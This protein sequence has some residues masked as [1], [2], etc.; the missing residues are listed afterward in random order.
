MKFDLKKEPTYLDRLIKAAYEINWRHEEQPNGI[1]VLTHFS[2]PT[3]LIQIPVRPDNFLGDIR[4]YAAT[5]NRDEYFE[6]R[7]QQ[8]LEKLEA[9]AGIPNAQ[10]ILDEAKS[11]QFAVRSLVTTLEDIPVDPSAKKLEMRVGM[12]IT[13]TPEEFKE[14]NAVTKEG[15]DILREKFFSAAFL[16]S[17]ECYSE[18]NTENHDPDEWEH[19]DISY[20]F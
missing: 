8:E 20:Q 16:L 7:Y 6:Y 13:V 19:W 15:M 9:T 18:D 11:A 12:T 10:A 14:I 17:G 2:L 1:I 5:F 3:N 4:Q